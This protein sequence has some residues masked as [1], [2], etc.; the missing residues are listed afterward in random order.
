M[1]FHK[2][3]RIIEAN[4]LASDLFSFVIDSH[5]IA[6]TVQAGQFLHI[7]CG[8]S[9]LLRRPISV[10]DVDGSLVKL[11]YMSKG[12]GTRWLSE[13]KPGEQLDVLGPLGKGFDTGGR[14]LLLV[15]GGIGVP[16]LL[17][18]AR[19]AAN[20]GQSEKTIALLGF[21][22]AKRAVLLPEFAAVCDSVE[23]STDDGSLGRHGFVTDLLKFRLDKERFDGILACGPVKMLKLIAKIADEYDI[24][25]QVSLEERMGC[26]IGAC[27]VCSCKIKKSHSEGFARVCA[28]GPVFLSREV[29]WDEA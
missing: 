17:M 11:V 27:L 18:A 23:I 5:D 4:Q 22:N 28:D 8:D 10:C 19:Q 24:P 9:L 20:G 2:L 7:A 25:C 1:S 26:G 13:R 29:I 3:C 6:E 14:K 15:G 12:S 21:T 16:P